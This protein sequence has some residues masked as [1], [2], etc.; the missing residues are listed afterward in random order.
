MFDPNGG[1]CERKGYWEVAKMVCLARSTPS[2]LNLKKLSGLTD[3]AG[4]TSG[5]ALRL[6]SSLRFNSFV[7]FMCNDPV[8]PLFHTLIVHTME[9]EHFSTPKFTNDAQQW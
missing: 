8:P 1:C 3:K 7:F 5:K 9:H 4:C 6:C 2:L